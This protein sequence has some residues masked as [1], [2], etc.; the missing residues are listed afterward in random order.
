MKTI[1]RS[2]SFCFGRIFFMPVMAAFRSAWLGLAGCLLLGASYS[3]CAQN[4]PPAISTITDQV[5]DEDVPLI[6]IPFTVRDAESPLDQLRFSTK[7][8][9]P[10]S[11]SSS[12]S[13]TSMFRQCTSLC[14]TRAN[15]CCAHFSNTGTCRRLLHAI[16][17]QLPLWCHSFAT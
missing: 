16:P 5:T 6:D 1:V 11:V 14:S 12:G 4:T 2:P 9:F 13:V 3:V 10:G 7:F 15:L 17:T 8:L